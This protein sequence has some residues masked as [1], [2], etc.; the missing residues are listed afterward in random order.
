MTPDDDII[1]SQLK[2]LYEEMDAVYRA[3]ADQAGFSC[4][5]C[6]GVR[7]CTVDVPIHTYAEMVYLIR[8]IDELSPSLQEEIGHRARRLVW[9]K[10]RAPQGVEYRNAVCAVNFEG[11]CALYEYRPMICRLAG[12]PYIAIRPDMTSVEGR[13]CER[14]ENEFEPTH[15]DLVLDRSSFYIRMSQLELHAVKLRRRKTP[16]HTVGEIIYYGTQG[17]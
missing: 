11:Q 8:G 3:A 9:A 2:A 6:D 7:C 13:G 15:P 10:D 17:L 5:G 1:I 16:V 14:F 12:I 4:H